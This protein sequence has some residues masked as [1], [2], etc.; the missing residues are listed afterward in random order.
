MTAA[1][2]R[3]GRLAARYGALPRFDP[4]QPRDPDGKWG[5][6]VGPS[7]AD[8][9][10]GYTAAARTSIGDWPDD[11]ITEVLAA[12]RDDLEK[13]PRLLE[14][15]RKQGFTGKPT[16]VSKE[17]FDALGDDHTRVFRGLHGAM[18][19]KSGAEYA[20][21]YRTADEPYPG[22]GIFGNGTYTTTRE[23]KADKYAHED[24][25][26]RPGGLLR[27]ALIPDARVATI[28]DLEK[29]L[30][31]GDLTGD[32]A[33]LVGDDTGKLA[34]MLGYDAFRRRDNIVVL[35]RTALIVQ[36]AG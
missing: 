24:T 36:E 21:E 9:V 29:V 20:E 17:E 31:S 15:W 22:L 14:L 28:D 11:D 13:D 30:D 26:G 1:V 32:V 18:G 33:D 23:D 27:M 2:T 10:A 6:G 35:N 19:G 3:R 7:G 25:K 5:D 12:P 4:D 16:V 34:T 8:V